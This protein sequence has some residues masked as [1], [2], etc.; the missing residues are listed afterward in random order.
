MML[1]GI[2]PS[3]VCLYAAGIVFAFLGAWGA[4]VSAQLNPT[5][6]GCEELREGV[7]TA[8]I[9]LCNGHPACSM[10]LKLQ[11][12][13][14]RTRAFLDKLMKTTANRKISTSDVFE[15]I[16]PQ[17]SG[18]PAYSKASNELKLMFDRQLEK[19]SSS[20]TYE[21]GNTWIYEG[22]MVN[23]K[24]HGV[25]IFGLFTPSQG[26]LYRAEF[27]AGRQVGKGEFIGIQA[28]SSIAEESR[29][30]YMRDFLHNGNGIERS[31][32]GTRY[33]GQFKDDIR[34]GRG[35]STYSTGNSY[36][37]EYRGG[38]RHGQGAYLW[39]DGDKFVGESREGNFFNG[40]LTNAAGS[41]TATLLNG[42]ASS[43]AAGTHL[44][45]SN[46][47]DDPKVVGGSFRR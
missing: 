16:A 4:P 19:S 37:G 6:A 36:E 5:I 17:V 8:Q 23:G 33:I 46:Y 10:T 14:V 35:M 29:V 38:Q 28:D 22:P 30:G 41:V 39:Q 15:A 31:S 20:G 11:T 32:K 42:V 13:C 3:R 18:D 2:A 47:P 40:V 1:T 12:N 9:R 34:E 45:P 21:N 7:A 43:P 24:R 27:V 25:G 44:P 26:N